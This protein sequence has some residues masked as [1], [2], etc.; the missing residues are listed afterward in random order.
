MTRRP[1]R[2]PL[3]PSPT[4]FR[5]LS[6]GERQRVALARA[7]LKGAD[8]LMLDEATSALDSRTEK[9]IQDAINEAIVGRTAIVV[10]HR[11]ST[12]MNADKIIVIESGRIVEQGPVQELL[13][14]QGAFYEFWKAQN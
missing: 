8:I 11:L 14:K 12:I 7:F 13:S 5:S 3:F 6:G 9:R 1:P 4:L 2:S 10:A